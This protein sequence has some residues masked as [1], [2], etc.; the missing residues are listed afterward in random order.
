MSK[1]LL[2][3][4]SGFFAMLLV[5]VTSFAL[6]STMSTMHTYSTN[7]SDTLAKIKETVD[8]NAVMSDFAI[9][10]QAAFYRHYIANNGDLSGPD[11]PD[12]NKKS[13]TLGNQDMLCLNKTD[14]STCL[15]VVYGKDSFG[16]EVSED[17]CATFSDFSS[18][19]AFGNCS[20]DKVLCVTVAIDAN[21][22]ENPP[23]TADLAECKSC[24][25][26]PLKIYLDIP[27]TTCTTPTCIADSTT[28][29]TCPN[30]LCGAQEACPPGTT[31]DGAGICT[32]PTSCTDGS[33]AV[34]SDCNKCGA[35]CNNGCCNGGQA[36]TG[37]Y[38]ICSAIRTCERLQ[39]GCDRDSCCD[40]TSGGSFPCPNKLQDSSSG[41][42]T[43]KY[44]CIDRTLGNKCYKCNPVLN[45][46]SCDESPT[47]IT[48][49]LGQTC[50]P[51]TGL[52]E[53]QCRGFTCTDD[54]SC[55]Y[56]DSNTC[57]SRCERV[58][59]YSTC[60]KCSRGE[61]CNS[62]Q[63]CKWGACQDPNN[64]QP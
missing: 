44:P 57:G 46:A 64:I 42:C 36:C 55:G 3:N 45:E 61:Q 17:Y 24:F 13:C 35:T 11:C 54:Q 51:G 33:C 31:C 32:P 60:M 18:V 10:A 39:I 22:K 28:C 7:K 43:L 40:R 6:W 2:S 26:Q 49:P 48:C 19:D 53:G 4:Q 1:H 58:S 16:N 37:H 41:L 27:D 52:C 25:V 59:P 21:D 63:V 23:A 5:A 47:P 56:D 14:C 15:E 29:E 30:G 50:N 38:T 20:N 9:E 34:D 12:S 62:N 8:M